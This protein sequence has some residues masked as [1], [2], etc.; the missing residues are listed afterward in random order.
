LCGDKAVEIGISCKES[1]GQVNL[2]KVIFVAVV[3]A[4][5]GFGQAGQDQKPPEEKV[6]KPDAKKPASAAKKPNP[7]GKSE[8][9]QVHGHWVLEA[10]NPD[11]TL[12]SRKEFENTFLVGPASG[13]NALATILAGGASVGGWYVEVEVAGCSPTCPNFTLAQAPAICAG[14]FVPPGSTCTSSLTAVV[15]GINL[16]QLTL[17]G[18]SVPVA[19]AATVPTVFTG[20]LTCDPG[21]TPAACLAGGSGLKPWFF[22][23]ATGVNF[24]VLAGQTITATV[25]LTF[26]PGA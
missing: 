9:I 23:T 17:Q 12:G 24:S 18:T 15:G 6:A 14:P 11:G 16:N 5:L 8:G 19:N 26:A 20:L 10:R 4:A 25:T 7:G 13:G 1:E 3:G 22:T 21:L 2:I